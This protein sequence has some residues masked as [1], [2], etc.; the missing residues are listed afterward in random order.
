MVARYGGEEFVVVLPNATRQGACNLAERFREAVELAPWEQR[1]I[2][3]SVGVATLGVDA[4]DR[5]GLILGS[6]KALYRAKQNGRNQ[7]IHGGLL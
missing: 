2:T 4:T 1:A 6:D 7:V 3:I 5:N